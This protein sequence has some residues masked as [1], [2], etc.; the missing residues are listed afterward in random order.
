MHIHLPYAEKINI[1]IGSNQKVLHFGFVYI[2][3]WTSH[4]YFLQRNYIHLDME[5]LEN[6]VKTFF[7]ENLYMLVSL[8]NCYVHLL[9]SILH[10]KG[11]PTEL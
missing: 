10:C 1:L 8:C 9:L 5:C 3:L 4:N 11:M 7:S 6:I 2:L